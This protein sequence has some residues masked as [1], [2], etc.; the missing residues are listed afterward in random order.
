MER[1]T[2]VASTLDGFELARIDLE[3]RSEGDVLGKA[4]SGTKSHLRLL[5]VL[6]DE[7]VIVEAREI[8]A[9]LISK[10]PSLSEIPALANEVAELREEEASSYLDKS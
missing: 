8:A 2:A 5:R 7:S 6:R 1:L 9:T 10:D 3:Q 4:Q